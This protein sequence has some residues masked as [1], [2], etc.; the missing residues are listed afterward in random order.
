MLP[1]FLL[2]SVLNS[3]FQLVC[4]LSTKPHRK[5][6][7]DHTHNRLADELAR[8]GSSHLSLRLM[9]LQRV[10]GG[11]KGLRNMSIAGQ[12]RVYSKKTLWARLSWINNYSKH[13]SVFIKRLVH[14]F[15][16]VLRQE[17]VTLYQLH[18]SLRRY[19]QVRGR[20]VNA[21][22]AW[23]ERRCAEWM[24]APRSHCN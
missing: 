3:S 15:M 21:M 9:Y 6:S 17:A 18:V 16:Y 20:R 24:R 10:P 7:F 19:A 14:K 13:I 2:L 23:V 1:F 4:A 5:N 12:A 22:I 11:D 8:Q